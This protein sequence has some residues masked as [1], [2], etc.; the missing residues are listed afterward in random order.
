[1]ALSVSNHNEILAGLAGFVPGTKDGGGRS[2]QDTPGIW[3]GYGESPTQRL[4][5]NSGKNSFHQPDAVSK[6]TAAGQKPCTMYAIRDKCRLETGASVC[7]EIEML[8]RMQ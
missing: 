7:L 4:K 2:P 3:P 5:A 1:V 6:P 8:W